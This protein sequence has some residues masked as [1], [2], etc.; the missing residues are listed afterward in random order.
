MNQ[1]LNLFA[2]LLLI[3]SIASQAGEPREYH[4]QGLEF[5]GQISQILVLNGYCKDENDCSKKD[6]VFLTNRNDGFLISVYGVEGKE[7]TST[8]VDK[9]YSYYSNHEKDISLSLEVDSFSHAESPKIFFMKK[10]NFSIKLPAYE[11][12]KTD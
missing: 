7:I 12:P 8:M 2:F 6:L 9:L 3:F 1:Y 11:Q 5:V 10:P 4:K